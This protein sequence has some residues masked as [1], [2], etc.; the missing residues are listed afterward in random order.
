MILLV[1]QEMIL[2]E[3]EVEHKNTIYDYFKSEF[4]PMYNLF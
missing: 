1:A 3:L 4:F 2:N